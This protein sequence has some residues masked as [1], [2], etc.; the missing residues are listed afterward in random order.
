MKRPRVVQTIFQIPVDISVAIFLVYALIKSA[1]NQL[2]SQHPLMLLSFGSCDIFRVST[3]LYV[4]S[5]IFP[6]I[7]V[8]CCL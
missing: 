3:I 8:T 4:Y 5:N 2:K 7:H 1:E 6:C